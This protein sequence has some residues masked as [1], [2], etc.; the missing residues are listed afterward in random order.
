MATPGT[1]PVCLLP[2]GVGAEDWSPSLRQQLS[3][4]QVADSA[5]GSPT[6]QWARLMALLF[7]DA[8]KSGTAAGALGALAEGLI[9][10]TDTTRT[11]ASF[12][13][14]SLRV[15]ARSAVL[16]DAR[17]FTL[18]A[19][20]ATELTTALAPLLNDV[21]MSIGFADPA[22]W[23]VQGPGLDDPALSRTPLM[24]LPEAAGR[25]A[26]LGLP[27]GREGARWR[28]LF[29]EVQ[30]ILHTHPVNQRRVMRGELPINSVWPWGMG[31]LA[32]LPA[33]SVTPPLLVSADQAVAVRGLAAHLG[34]RW[35]ALASWL[36]L[37]LGE[38]PAGVVCISPAPLGE[39]ETCVAELL[40]AGAVLNAPEAHYQR[41]PPIRRALAAAAAWGR[42]LA[43][44]RRGRSR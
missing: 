37:P 7:G 38:R 31:R 29:N 19:N 43:R 42:T 1:R 18:T 12:D 5:E 14:V 32:D 17:A 9:A 6:D 20:E 10:L 24:P 8:V 33:P 41:R 44:T 34:S 23:Y 16:L 36:A 3:R 35:M 11:V 22:R 2:D 15:D 27:G 30:M 26:H 21:G 39:L 28:A 4:S 25:E 40:E 13:P